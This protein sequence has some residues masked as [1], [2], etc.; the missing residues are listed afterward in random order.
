MAT[1]GRSRCGPGQPGEAAPFP[2]RLRRGPGLYLLRLSAPS[3]VLLL[4]L[5]LYLLF[6]SRIAPA[7]EQRAE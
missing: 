1:C 4:S 6:K 7:S 3:F 2:S 5:I